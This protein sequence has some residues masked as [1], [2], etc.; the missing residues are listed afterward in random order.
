MAIALRYAARSDVG[1][2]RKNNQD[3]AYAGPHLL[4]VAD[5]MGGHAGGDV[6]SSIAV[7]ELAGLDGESHGSDALGHLEQSVHRAHTLL[8]RRVEEEPDLAGMGTTLTALLRSGGKFALVHIGDS[9]AY[10]LRDGEMAQVTTDHTYV[11][12]LVEEGRPSPEEA[13]HHPQRN[14]IMRVLGDNETSDE[15]DTSVREARVGDRWLLCSDGLSGLISDETVAD[16]LRDVADPGECADQL[17]QLA[18]RAGGPDNVTCIVADVVAVSSAPSSTPQ[19][20]GSA[21]LQ[22]SRPS[23]ASG[24][25]AA[26]AAAVAPPNE[27]DD[28]DDPE[29]ESPRRGRKALRLVAALAVLAVLLGGGYAA[30]AWS[31]QQYYVGPDAGQVAIY[32]GLTQDIGPIGLSSVYE[33]QDIALD[34]LDRVYRERVEDLIPADDLGDAR[35]IVDDLFQDSA[36]CEPEP[37]AS[38]SATTPTPAPS[39]TT[40]PV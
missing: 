37:A 1:L 35:R 33:T 34:D 24:G 9:R 28:V 8:Q 13:E 18:L 31:Q 23:V 17:V 14:V 29:T 22:R 30:Y 32:R 25:A 11:Q 6:A 16:T 20:V 2:V 36:L 27:S 26:R 15:L 4:V 39:P 38:P 12:R 5:G 7:G 3:S 40:A 10:L 19:I 21:A